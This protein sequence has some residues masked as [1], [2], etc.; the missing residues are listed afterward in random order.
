[1][2]PNKKRAYLKRITAFNSKAS[3]EKLAHRHKFNIMP[4]TCVVDNAVNVHIVNEKSLFKD[5][6]PCSERC[7]AT[8]GGSDLK[9]EGIGTVITQIT[10]D[11]S[12]TSNVTLE[13][14]L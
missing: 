14:A 8:I 13:N 4:I 1:M 9:P 6:R 2:H 12:T 10:D 7:V 3:A 5:I 11:N